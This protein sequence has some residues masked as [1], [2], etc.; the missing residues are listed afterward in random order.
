MGGGGNVKTKIGDIVAPILKRGIGISF[1]GRI[2][3]GNSGG[4]IN[5]LIGVGNFVV[6]LTSNI[7]ISFVGTQIGFDERIIIKSS[8]F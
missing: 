1:W 6:G 4:V 7:S 2:V 3:K 5:L 8:G